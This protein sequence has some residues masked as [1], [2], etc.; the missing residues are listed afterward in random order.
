MAGKP[1]AL[2]LGDDAGI[3]QCVQTMGFRPILADL[4][5]PALEMQRPLPPA[6][7][8]VNPPNG[9]LPPPLL[10]RPSRSGTPPLLLPDEA[11]PIPGPEG[12]HPPLCVL[13]RPVSPGD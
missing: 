3:G 10:R 11:G 2:I 5:N 12:P 1:V 8:L 6:P 7:V 13:K 9:D 4:P